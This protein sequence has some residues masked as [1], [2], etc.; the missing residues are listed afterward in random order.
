MFQLCD[1]TIFNIGYVRYTKTNKTQ[2]K[3]NYNTD[4]QAS[5]SLATAVTSVSVNCSSIECELLQRSTMYNYNAKLQT[6]IMS[7]TT[8]R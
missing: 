4:E 6:S 1:I 2:K 7:V 3:T 8:P 5:V